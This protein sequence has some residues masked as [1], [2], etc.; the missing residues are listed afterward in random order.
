M[1]LSKL[2]KLFMAKEWITLF[3]FVA[4]DFVQQ[5]FAQKNS[6]VD[7]YKKLMSQ[8]LTKDY[9]DKDIVGLIIMKNL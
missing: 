7:F 8:I 6:V 9:K 4:L 5:C 3:G 1:K 2:P